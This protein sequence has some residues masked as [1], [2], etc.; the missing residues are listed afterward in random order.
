MTD[1]WVLGSQS[2][3]HPLTHMWTST[4]LHTHTHIFRTAFKMPT[5]TCLH[6][7]LCE[8]GVWSLCMYICRNKNT[9]TNLE[10]FICIK[11]LKKCIF[12]ERCYS[13]E[14]EMS[15]HTQP[16]S[17]TDAQTNIQA[18]G[19]EFG[20]W[21]E[22]NICSNQC[23]CF[24]FAGGLQPWVEHNK[25]LLCVSLNKQEGIWCL[26][27]LLANTA[28]TV[29]ATVITAISVVATNNTTLLAIGVHTITNAK[30]KHPGSACETV[31]KR[32]KGT[33]GM[34]GHGQCIMYCT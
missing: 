24:G 8:K 20:K 7:K 21:H 25:A 5:H 23:Q 34:F 33:T 1:G 30:I 11:G 32:K 14:R 4:S 28:L 16:D 31:R 18:D 3:N 10:H 6:V 26:L 27:L 2:R 17:K 22:N 29:T 13:T 12:I 19:H 15:R 9:E